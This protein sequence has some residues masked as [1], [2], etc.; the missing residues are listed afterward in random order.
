VVT[1]PYELASDAVR[2]GGHFYP[3]ISELEEIKRLKC[4]F[5]KHGDLVEADCPAEARHASGLTVAFQ[6]DPSP[7]SL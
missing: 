5:D 3:V 7:V 6:A 2:S 1:L 4:D